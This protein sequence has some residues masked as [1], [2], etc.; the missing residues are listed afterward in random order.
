VTGG[1]HSDTVSPHRRRPQSAP[2]V[3]VAAPAW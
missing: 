1:R 3:A 2:G